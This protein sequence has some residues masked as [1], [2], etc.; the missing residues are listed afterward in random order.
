MFRELRRLRPEL[1][2]RRFDLLLHLQLSFRASLVSTLVH[3]AVKLGFD[4]PRARELQWWF[5]NA[6]VEPALREHVLDSFMGFAR[7]CGVEP[8]P[9]RWDLPLTSDGLDYA[10][11]IIS[12]GRRTLLISPCSSHTARNWSAAHYA[13][14]ADHAVRVHD[15]RV[16]AGRGPQFSRSP[17]GRGPSPPPPAH[18]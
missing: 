13:A 9:A 3:A 18:P 5:T 10:R 15:M 1:R 11:G 14:V 6:T 16:R 17:G 4:R 8:G 12:D 2:R 7:A